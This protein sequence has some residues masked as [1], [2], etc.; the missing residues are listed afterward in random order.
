MKLAQL[1]W[2]GLIVCATALS[3]GGVVA[4][5]FAQAQASRGSTDSNPFAVNVAASPAPGQELKKELPRPVSSSEA[6][7]ARLKALESKL[8]Q[9]LSRP[10]PNTPPAPGI[11]VNGDDPFRPAPPSDRFDLNSR[12]SKEATNQSIR[13]QEAALKLAL[14]EYDATAKLLTRGGISTQELELARGKVLLPLARLEGLADEIADEHA[15]LSLEMRRKR[16]EQQRAITQRELASRVV[17]WNQ[18]LKEQTPARHC[19]TSALPKRKL[20][21]QD[22]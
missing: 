20:S 11:A 21:L 6:I 2:I 15:L 4:V 16:A 22:F 17:A 5:S 1:K 10:N 7:E 8:D 9:V 3:A 19:R 18:R 14:I 13:E 12:S